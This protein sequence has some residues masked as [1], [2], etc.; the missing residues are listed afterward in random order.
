MARMAQ[1]VGPNDVFVFFYSGHGSQ[2]EGSR[3]VREIDQIDETIHVYD[4]DIVDDE[5][6]TMLDGFRTNL[7]VVTLDSC[8]SGGFAKDVITRPGRV[9]FFSSQEDVESAVATQFQAGG[10]LSY[11]L[12]EGAAGEA[13]TNPHDSVL[14]VGE[15]E[16][17]L[18]NQFGQNARDIAMDGA[19]QHLV[20]D[21]GAVR[22]QQVLFRYH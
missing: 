17:Y 4:G 9:G 8:F 16:H 5:F 7:A 20:T 21:R 11:F 2:R 6:G 18:V 15:L 14:T 13:D 12:R 22:G 10:Y 19:F 3:D 1:D